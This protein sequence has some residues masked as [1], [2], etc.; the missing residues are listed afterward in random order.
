MTGR[1]LAVACGTA[2]LVAATPALVSAQACLGAPS[3]STHHLQIS[4]DV[5]GDDQATTFGAS[6]VSG[7]ETLFAGL[8][9]G[10]ATYANANGSTLLINGVAGFQVPLSVGGA[11]IC[12]II[13]AGAGF[14][15]NDIDGAG[16]KFSSHAVSFALSVGGELLKSQSLTIVPALSFGFVY[17]AA[18]FEEA[19]TT[20]TETDTYASAGATLGIVLSERL[21]IRPNVTVPI[22]LDGAKPV[23][24]VG[25]SL[26]YGGRR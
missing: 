1:S 3:F 21:S 5:V 12:P 14:G 6:F 18:S 2:L 11:Q 13:S 8:G 23:Y 20:S 7:S 4:A 10:G 16:T 19:F 17:Q 22:G 24:G 25:F 15:P 9:L 26:N